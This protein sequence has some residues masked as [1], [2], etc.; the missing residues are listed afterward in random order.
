M[1]MGIGQAGI[2]GPIYL[3]EVA[4]TAWRGLLVCTYA[5][6]E[7]IGVLIGYFAGYGASLHLSNNSD[8]QWNVPQSCQIMFSGILLLFSSAVSKAPDT[9]V[10]HMALSKPPGPLDACADSPRTVPVSRTNYK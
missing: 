2:I 10:K 9:C 8:Q 7:Y 6:S 3:A 1:G 4:P 5:S